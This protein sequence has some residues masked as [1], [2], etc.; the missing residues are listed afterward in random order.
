MSSSF[1]DERFGAEQYAYGR[2]PNDFLRQ[3]AARIP[4][5]PVLC[6]ADGEGRNSTF[7]AGLG[8]EV[9]AVDYSAVGL[10]K[11]RR[12]ASERG[13]ALTTVEADLAEFE[14]PREDYAG[15]VAIF[16]HLP[17]DVR[18]RVHGWAA[19]ALRPGGVFVLEAY[20]LAQLPLGTGGPRDPALLM[21]LSALEQELAPLEIVLGQELERELQE[22]SF[23]SGRSATVQ[24]VAVRPAQP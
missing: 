24:L 3:Q 1:W 5:G 19:R 11:A 8:H 2:E 10:Q 7:L 4:A 23:H 13:V 15:I 9:T 22:G 16:A 17:V 21:S 12:L 20:T 18:R 14:P 6:L